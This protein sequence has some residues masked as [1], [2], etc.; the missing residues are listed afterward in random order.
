METIESAAGVMVAAPMPWTRERPGE[1]AEE[2]GGREHRDAGD[3][4][5]P[6]PE[7]VRR[8]SSEQEQAAVGEGIRAHHP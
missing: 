8:P 3:E 1:P 5:A 2:R 4:H 6:A 7:Q